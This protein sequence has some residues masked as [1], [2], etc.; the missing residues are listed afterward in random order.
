MAHCWAVAEAVGSLQGAPLTVAE[1]QQAL[2]DDGRR[3]AYTTVMT[4]MGRLVE[5]GLLRRSESFGRSGPGSSYRYWPAQ[6]E[7]AFIAA[8]SRE[9]ISALIATF[10][11]VALAQFADAL[12]TLDPERLAALARLG[13][14][15]HDIQAVELA[16]PLES[17]PPAHTDGTAPSQV[18]VASTA[19]QPDEGS[20]VG[21]DVGSDEGETGGGRGEGQP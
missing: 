6:S 20:D 7:A 1:V 5:K 3:S 9:R 15:I 8:A 19:H 12:N 2:T 10:G 11:D 14:D 13:Q 16:N 4:V 17:A 21:S 18:S